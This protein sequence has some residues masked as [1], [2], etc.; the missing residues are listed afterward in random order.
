[1]K[2]G[3][4]EER[5]RVVP[6]QPGRLGS[7]AGSQQ[8]RWDHVEPVDSEKKTPGEGGYREKLQEAAEKLTRA[9]RVF[10]Y[11]LHF[12]IHEDTKRVM[13]QVID[14]ETDEVVNEVPPEKIL[15]LVAEIWRLVGLLVDEKV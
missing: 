10:D 4:A 14:E 6:H 13:V 3:P 5:F 1:M 8:V 7:A 2:V 12:K 15:N 9:A 11:K